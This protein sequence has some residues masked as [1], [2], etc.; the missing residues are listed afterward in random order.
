MDY[1]AMFIMEFLKKY[2][3]LILLVI[4]NIGIW[5]YQPQKEYTILYFTRKNFLNF[6]FMIVP[7][8]ICIGLMDIWIKQKTMVKI[9][10]KQSGLLGMITS[11]LLGMVTA[12]P[13]YALSPVTG[14]LLKKGS[15]I[16][17]VIL[18]ICSS[19]SI[20][21]P[22]LLFEI[23]S[24]GIKF[25]LIRLLLNIIVIIAIAFFTEFL[26]TGKDKKEMYTRIEEL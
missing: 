26:L 21:I 11:L 18:F 12:V 5:I 24:L 17:N 6:I 2:G 7:V 16:S 8:F 3:M 23:S 22:L 1:G 10:G 20:R 4:I 15:G 19:A 13:S 25:T 9:M 14:V